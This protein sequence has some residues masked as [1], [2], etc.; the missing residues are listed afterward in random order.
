MSF[1]SSYS[2]IVVVD[3]RN[4]SG[5]ITLPSALD[6]PGRTLII[7]D[8]YLSFDKNP[9]SI[10][11][12]GTDT[13]ED[14]TNV[15]TLSQTGG[16]VTL[17]AAS[18][19]WYKIESSKNLDTSVQRLQVST[20]NGEVGSIS[21]L[22]VS[23][24][25]SNI[26]DPQLVSTVEGLG[27][28]GYVSSLQLDPIAIG[29]SA[30]ISQGSY[31]VAIGNQ[32]GNT[33]QGSSSVAIGDQAGKIAQGNGA[34]A[35][36]FIAGQSNQGAVS[37]AIGYNSGVATQSGY[38]TAIG[39]GA[40]TTSQGIAATA[41][42]CVVGQTN[43]GSNAVAV[44]RGV[45]QTDQG[46]SAVAIGDYAGN[47][48]Q[49]SSAVAIGQNAGQNSQGSKS[50][51]IGFNAGQNS[52]GTDCIALGDSAGVT[53][54][55]NNSIILNASGSTLDSITNGFF[56]SPIRSGGDSNLNFL[57][58]DSTN[59]EVL[60]IN[61]SLLKSM[62]LI[63][64]VEGLGS[65]GYL[66]S[67]SYSNA[68]VVSTVEGLGSVGYLSSYSNAVFEQGLVSS[69]EGLGSLGYLSSQS[70]SNAI[71]VSTVEGLGSVGYLSS[72]SNAVFE[73]GLVSSLEG[74]GTLGYISSATGG[75]I[76]PG[77][78]ISTVEGL[79]SIGYI[80]TPGGGGGIGSG[81]LVSTVEGLGTVGYISSLD[82][83]N[84]SSLYVS[85]LG[86]YTLTV[87]GPST[88]NVYGRSVLNTVEA[89]SISTQGV[90]TSTIYLDELYT[91][92]TH[93][94]T[95]VYTSTGGFTVSLLT[96]GAFADGTTMYYTI[97]GNTMNAIGDTFGSEAKQV[98]YNSITQ[99]LFAVG[100]DPGGNNLMKSS[101]DAINWSTLGVTP[102]SNINSV[103][104]G[105]NAWI[106]GGNYSTDSF[107]IWRSL[108]GSSWSPATGDGP[109]NYINGE[110]TSF[111][112]SPALNLWVAGGNGDSNLLRYSTDG[113]VNWSFAA[114]TESEFTQ[115]KRIIWASTV[116]LFVA[117]GFDSTQSNIKYS[118]DGSNWSNAT[119]NFN[120][121]KG[122]AYA[123]D[124]AYDEVSSR[125]VV[126]ITTGGYSSGLR[127][128][129]NGTNWESIVYSGGYNPL[130]VYAVGYSSNLGTWVAGNGTDY[131]S[132]SDG[133]SWSDALQY[134]AINGTLNSFFAPPPSVITSNAVDYTASTSVLF[135][136]NSLV[137]NNVEFK[138]DSSGLV[139]TVEGLGNVGYI[140]S[141]AT[142]KVAV[143]FGAGQ[144]NQGDVGVAVG[145]AA[146]YS[147]QAILA[148]AIGASAGQFSQQSNSVAIGTQAGQL[149]QGNTSIA[150]GNLASYSNQGSNAISIGNS[151]GQNNQADY[152]IAM[153]TGAGYTSQT[154]NAIA[155]GYLTG[156]SNQSNDSIAIG[157][158]AAQDNQ[159]EYAISIGFQAGIGNQGCNAICMGASSGKYGQGQYAISLGRNAGFS[160]QGVAAVALGPGA[161]ENDQSANSIA[162]GNGAGQVSQYANTVAV[163]IN[164]GQV[165]QGSNAVAVGAATAQ[166]GQ[167]ENAVAVGAYAGDIY[168]S[169]NAVSIGYFAGYSNQGPN[170][171][172]VGINAG[173][174]I[175]GDNSI[176]IGANAGS[177]LQA[178]NSIGIG[179]QAG[180]DTQ[181]EA[182]IALGYSA[183]QYN[184][185]SFT[186]AIGNTAGQTN[187]STQSIAI[188]VASGQTNQTENAIAIGVAA[189][190]VN[191][192]QN[193]VAIGYQAGYS[194]QEVNS[195]AIGQYAGLSLQ[196]SSSIILNA[197]GIELNA[198]T[199]G[200]Y[201]AP[202]ASGG[203]SNLNFLAYD[204]TN[205]QVVY[206]NPSILQSM[207]LISTVEGLGSVGYIS[208][209]M[210]QTVAI[211]LNA[212]SSNQ[213]TNSI[214]VGYLA[215][216]SN[217]ASN[218]IAIGKGAGISFQ[219]T[220]SVAIGYEAGG[221]NQNQTAVA[222]G[223]QTGAQFQ[224]IDT[225]AIGNSAGSLYQDTG[226]IAIGQGAGVTYQST[227]SIAIGAGAGN[228]YQG[229]GAVAV[230]YVSGELNQGSNA[231]SLGF[232]AG[233][234]NQG[235]Y[236]VAIGAFAGSALQASTS[237]IL[238]ATGQ[239]LNAST[240]GFYVSPINLAPSSNALNLLFY[241]ST[242]SEIV[243]V[244]PSTVTLFPRLGN[245]LTVDSVNGNDTTGTPSGLPY[246]TVNA[247][248]SNLIPGDTVWILPGVYQLTSS[249]YM[250]DNTSLRGMSLQ[251]VKLVL[252]NVSSATTML[253]MGENC[254]VEDLQLYLH[255]ASNY[256]L[257]GIEFPG[258]THYTSKLRTA[259]VTVDN[260][261]APYTGSNNSYA[262][263]FTGSNNLG[264]QAFSFNSLKGSTA[265]LFS[266]GGGRKRAV[267]VSGNNVIVST[268]DMNLYCAAPVNSNSAGSY[269]G[270]E[271]SNATSAIQ[272]RATTV[273]GP[274]SAGSYS[275]SDILQ[276]LGSIEIGPGT[277]IVHKT[278][279]RSSFT[280][281]VYP[282][283]V[284][285][286]IKG[287]LSNSGV[288]SGY[289]WPGSLNAQAAQGHVAAYPDPVIAYYRVQQRSI[290]NAFTTYLTNGP[291]DSA[292]THVTVEVNGAE[293]PF[294]IHYASNDSGFKVFSTASYDLKLGDL[295]TVKLDLS[296]IGTNQSHDMTV[297]LD[298][299]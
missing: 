154:S 16:Y 137:I 120:N 99:E 289:L 257:V 141:L 95:I 221:L 52:Q 109:N 129:S 207:D 205:S 96:L 227:Y 93:I 293:T 298:L 297:Q 254:R 34:V 7:K 197:T 158:L 139:S 153:G 156:Q 233:C 35:I 166:T 271:T 266:N 21:S 214:A 285:Y 113:G 50:I 116:A 208:S 45:A 10:S 82:V 260:S 63:S 117:V 191:Q 165:S 287:D 98:A 13:F 232:A 291:Q 104:F 258:T 105:S 185:G 29:K 192:G 39:N 25:N 288:T 133:I 53:N 115:V 91:N 24:I 57:A 110:A 280:T 145:N 268:R 167:G 187:Q 12:A 228:S 11:T 244:D 195:I 74:L 184:Q 183:G 79:G 123:F 146:G 89:N 259:V 190:C 76:S 30:G 40:G 78:L 240:S 84:V 42:G 62:D 136:S 32:A 73:Q 172:A 100:T 174:N 286:G 33:T 14:G 2:G 263:H 199:Y 265:N 284:Y 160:N 44:G 68:I 220:Y 20:L 135:R 216:Q 157:T 150:I 229:Q 290:M 278:A 161:G 276:T 125:F 70:Y 225:I 218:A 132:S 211:G 67:Q 81:D 4:Q 48:T 118:S 144:I 23:S 175:Q 43:Q 155:I 88:L 59:A 193:S 206:I 26:I 5:T 182:S 168:Q 28:L 127:T 275:G 151:A 66:S 19:F 262:L 71:V 222:I 149:Y 51:A 180:Y 189:G 249:I 60:Y 119:G 126:G 247:A 219:S 92:N 179:N 17:I 212:G 41:I 231:I 267:L 196:V 256:D 69:L 1:V 83:L 273:S 217:Q 130:V 86:A 148:L 235:E 85:S 181:G 250:P 203:S 241:N 94:S 46:S 27:S 142:P 128:S 124:V 264:E 224:G 282:T 147:N 134:K 202:I 49:G 122:A 54:Q 18:T 9:V 6:V 178:L 245:T 37:V 213:G 236:S 64:T 277:D 162:I 173:Y 22:I 272:L 215:G 186:V 209:L 47:L 171:I 8:E 121:P 31:S 75:G 239:E 87:N 101:R 169:T 230:G 108:D 294:K 36:G 152:S 65:L 226:A 103:A 253:T 164:A 138:L 238:N 204:S 234:S 97:D 269:V 274:S 170:T 296:S 295:I 106:V 299:F 246:K 255:S 55:A 112:Y 15:M 194:N 143:G 210:F 90:T 242:T 80:S 177:N 237:I 131:W 38:A 283:V 261:N 61:P 279:G 252:S 281:Y 292:S 251:T 56:V 72:Y 159:A 176:A 111:A 198:S 102:F 243:Q 77:E 3:S 163:G 188:G 58:Y 200:F 114:S 201:V 270:I 248:L 140:S 107:T 223:Y